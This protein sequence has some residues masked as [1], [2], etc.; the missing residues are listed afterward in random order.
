MNIGIFGGSFNP[1]HNA[2]ISLAHTIQQKAGL[3]EVW[4]LVS[5]QNPLKKQ[6]S[7]L[8]EMVRFNMV[9]L[10]LSDYSA[11][12]ASDYEFHLERPSYTWNTL[13]N[14]KNDY[15][16]HSFTLIIGGDNWALFDKWAH[17]EEILREYSIVVY[18]REG[19]EIDENSLPSNVRLVHTPEINITSTMI[20]Q[21]I[22]DGET[23]EEYVPSVVSRVIKEQGYYLKT[24]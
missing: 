6:S 2:H 3:D 7:L 10:A 20:R 1:I 9:K 24:Y 15:P 12:I 23:F 18:P 13:C 16:D 11:L 5:P 8:D 21:K 17:H 19:C 4:F 14:L 22:A